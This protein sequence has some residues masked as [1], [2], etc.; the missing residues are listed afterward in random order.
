[1]QYLT[2]KTSENIYPQYRDLNT[3]IIDYLNGNHI[4]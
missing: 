3:L 4:L 2:V 1:M